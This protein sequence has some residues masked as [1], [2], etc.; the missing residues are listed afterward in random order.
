MSTAGP[1]GIYLCTLLQNKVRKEWASKY[2]KRFGETAPISFEKFPEM[3]ALTDAIKDDMTSSILPRLDRKTHIS[4]DTLKGYL[5][6]QEY[7]NVQ[8]NLQTSLIRYLSGLDF[9]TFRQNKKKAIKF[10]NLKQEFYKSKI[11]DA[12]QA[13]RSLLFVSLLELYT[14][15]KKILEV[16]AIGIK[17]SK[18]LEALKEFVASYPSFPVRVRLLQYAPKSIAIRERIFFQDRDD[19]DEYNN[20]NMLFRNEWERI[21]KMSEDNSFSLEIK[22]VSIPLFS[23]VRICDSMVVSPYTLRPGRTRAAMLMHMPKYPEF[24]HTHKLHFEKAFNRVEDLNDL[25]DA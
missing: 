3:R 20:R 9:E 6:A 13:T 23:Y 18:L 1:P 19:E 7:A 10:F 11:I 12:G 16:D 25:T 8:A 4:P 15:D 22:E 24:F 21:E 14:V 17:Q 2:S 5:L